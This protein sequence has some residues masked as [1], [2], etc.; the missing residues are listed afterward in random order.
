MR[1]FD[2]AASEVVAAPLEDCL[3]LLAAV[4]R[5][6]DWCPDVV[7]AVEVLDRGADGQASSVR[8]AMHIARGGFDREFDL[9]LTVIV[10]PPGTV[11]LTR[12]RKRPTS[13]EFNA[14]WMLTPAGSTRVAL[15]LDAKLR[16]P[17]FIRAHGIADA[18]AQGFVTAACRELAVPSQ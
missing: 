13:Q 7:R 2:G 1:E 15:H 8:M 6:A 10:E 11:K 12:V 9:F 4:D 14:A 3:V 16:V 17:R 5:Y 18:I